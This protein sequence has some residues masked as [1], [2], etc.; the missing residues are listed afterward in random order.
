MFSCMETVS[1]FMMVML[2]NNVLHL[3][4]VTWFQFTELANL[5]LQNKVT[6]LFR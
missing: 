6:G 4:T 5:I 2:E 1:L 3:Q